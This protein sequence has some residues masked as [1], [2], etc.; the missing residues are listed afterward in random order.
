MIVPTPVWF[1]GTNGVDVT[2]EILDF[3]KQHHF[4]ENDIRQHLFLLTSLRDTDE[5][6][7]KGKGK[8]YFVGK[9]PKKSDKINHSLWNE[10]RGLKY[11]DYVSSN[12]TDEITEYLRKQKVSPF[13]PQATPS[14][15]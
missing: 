2:G 14:E 15:E 5:Y 3:D 13:I 6:K 1:I 9:E 12:E 4:L 10:L 11:L 7:R 8:H